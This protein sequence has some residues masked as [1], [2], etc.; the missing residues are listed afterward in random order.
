MLC[1]RMSSAIE[2]STRLLEPVKRSVPKFRLTYMDGLRGF[3][4]I[5]VASHHLYLR[6]LDMAG[7]RF[8][9]A[10]RLLLTGHCFVAVF[11][12]LS[13]YTLMLPIARAKDHHMV[14]GW[15]RFISRRAR[16]ILP[17]YYAGLL[18]AIIPLLPRWIGWP[19][20]PWASRSPTIDISA[21]AVL[22]HVL[23]IQNL[24]PLWGL[25]INSAFWSISTEW[26]LYFLF[27]LLLLPIWRRLGGLACIAVGLSVGI[28][29]G[30]VIGFQPD[31]CPWYLGVFAMGMAGSGISFVEHGARKSTLAGRLPWGWIFLSILALDI[32]IMALQRPVRLE[33]TDPLMGLSVTALL[34]RC[35]YRCQQ[36]HIGA[37]STVGPLLRMLQS[38]FCTGVGTMSYSLYLVHMPLIVV[39]Q[40]LLT[41]RFGGRSNLSLWLLPLL[42][43]IT[44]AIAMSVFHHL[45]ERPFMVGH[46]KTEAKAA[47]SATLEPA[48]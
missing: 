15:W 44:V 39:L 10:W 41:W 18:L 34:I 28:A 20:L 19:H 9:N 8:P 23:L 1:G 30:Y 24:R 46:P 22:E 48:I 5:V 11:V 13:G 17:A 40:T 29:L 42:T 35:T 7:S 47:T 14:G 3:S 45:F 26:Q 37:I 16:R 36:K 2:S 33:I 12:V 21:A 6:W 4:A 38:R 32:L 27:P 25:Q 31:G 43:L